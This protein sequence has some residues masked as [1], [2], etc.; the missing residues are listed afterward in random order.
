MADRKKETI[1]FV[2]DEE[3]ILDVASLFFKRQGYLTLTASNGVEALQILEKESVDCCF[4]DI[5]MPVMN[6]LDLAENIR[7]HDNTMPVIVMTGYPSLENTIQTIKN[8]VVDFLIKPINLKQM[9]LCVQR[10]L[11]QRELFAE[12]V[13]L[14]EEVKSKERLEKLNQELLHK[15]EELNILNK[16]MSSFTSNLSTSNV[17]KRAVDLALEITHADNTLFHVINESV[18]QPFEVAAAGVET[19][20]KKEQNTPTPLQNDQN[21]THSESACA[22]SSLSG[23]IMEVVSDEIP[24]LI[25]KN[26]GACGL[27][28]N[29]LSVMV[30]P[31]KIRDKVFGVLTATNRK[32]AVPF[33]EKDLFYL[34][35]MA[36]SAAYSIE[37]LALYE[38]IY[39]N[40]LA[41]LYA[42]VNAVEA[43]DLYTRQH[44]SRVTGL[45]L[46]LGKQL[47]C[48]SEELD[49][50]N[51]AGHLHDIGKIGIR[52]DILL[53]PG[54]LTSDEFEKIKEHPVIGANILEQLGF[55]DKER[56]IIRYHHERF[57]GTGYPDGL[58]QEQ[59]PFLARILSV[60]DVYDA[61]ASDRAYRKRM[62]EEAILIVIHEGAGSQ[63]DPDVVEA[64]KKVYSQGI[65][66]DYMES[67][68]GDQ[69]GQSL[70]IEG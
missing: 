30:V 41:T 34:S 59:I 16:I 6:G 1:L 58:N 33:K 18:N 70:H 43:R 61:M 8:G 66:L 55:W 64:F 17:F 19:D 54:R 44:S 56:Q 10:V 51:F 35:F 68:Q 46:I 45:S 4:T 29:L 57:D 14:K 3:S 39:E 49:I 21:V 40:L 52:D 48:T 62:D 9:E 28:K 67:G 25:A 36:Q 60:A 22:T 50:L 27:P 2:D 15:V 23:L 37:N 32:N 11:R 26:N 31:L 5:N 24:L 7:Q 65:I 13:L 38:N 20:Q 42:F 12:N 47:G 53:K 63:F 69:S